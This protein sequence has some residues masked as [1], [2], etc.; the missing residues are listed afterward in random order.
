MLEQHQVEHALLQGRHLRAAVAATV[1]RRVIARTAHLSAL[2]M[3]TSVGVWVRPRQHMA[4]YAASWI[5][6][7]CRKARE[8]TAGLLCQPLVVDAEVESALAT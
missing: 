1:H 7:Q 5:V 8:L 3:R 4:L 2:L 6:R